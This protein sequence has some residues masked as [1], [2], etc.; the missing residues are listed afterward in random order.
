MYHDYDYDRYEDY[1]GPRRS[2]RK[3]YRCGGWASYDGPCGALD[4][5]DCH[6][7]GAAQM[8]ED[9]Y[10]SE[11]P[12]ACG[13]CDWDRRYSWQ[14]P[15]EDDRCRKCGSGRFVEGRTHSK[16]HTA[17]KHFEG[18]G[19]SEVRPGDRYRRTVTFG[20]FPDGPFTLTV[21]R[22]RIEKGP[23]WTE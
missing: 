6:P 14:G 8:E 16:T 17:R 3:V 23:A 22:T 4:C 12:C 20:H 5:E 21:T 1:D 10:D 13:E 15:S 11:H 9:E 19:S 18:H 2:T 7:G